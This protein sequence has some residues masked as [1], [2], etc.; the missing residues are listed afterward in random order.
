MTRRWLVNIC[1]WTYN[2]LCGLSL[3][4]GIFAISPAS[5]A[6]GVNVTHDA[7][8]AVRV[9]ASYDS[10]EPMAAAQ[11]SVFAPGN[12]E[13]PWITGTTDPTG[14]FA[15]V[16]DFTQTG[17]WEVQ[18]RLAGHGDIVYV[19][20]EDVSTAAELS[21]NASQ[22]T[23]ESESLAPPATRS[24]SRAVASPPRSPVGLSIGQKLVMG[25]VF[26]WGCV[27]TAL[28]VKRK[29]I[30]PSNPAKQGGLL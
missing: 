30:K 21:S 27:G 17:R 26:S 10:G 6:H 13:T 20:V 9:Q 1:H 3:G 5:W 14:N 29:T 2:S 23:E 15:F 12:V 4:V 22:N 24:P 7:G 18:V 11:V 8:E 16:P 28:Y 25:A 19:P